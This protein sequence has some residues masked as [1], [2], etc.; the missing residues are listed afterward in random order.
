MGT[1]DDNKCDVLISCPTMA[2]VDAINL[3]DFPVPLVI[4]QHLHE[5]TWRPQGEAGIPVN[6]FTTVMIANNTP[7]KTTR[8]PE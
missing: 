5:G 6:A 2:D 8:A 4:S 3:Q 7:P 1:I